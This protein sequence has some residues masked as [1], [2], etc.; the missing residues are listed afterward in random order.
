MGFLE[1]DHTTLTQE[2]LKSEYHELEFHNFHVSCQENVYKT[3]MKL[4][5]LHVEVDAVHHILP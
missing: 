5:L 4:T 2:V 1:K 3:K